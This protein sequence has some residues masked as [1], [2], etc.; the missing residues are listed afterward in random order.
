MEESMKALISRKVGMTS[1]IADDGV[2]QAVTLLSA[3]PC[4][5]TQ[6]KTDEVDGYTAVQI[7][8]GEAKLGKAQPRHNK[9][10][11]IS[12][13]IVREFRINEITEEIKVGESISADVFSVGDTVHVTGTS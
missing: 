6:L 5:I 12:P 1:I 13:K 7:G 11:K 9:P 8:T 2:V 4:V 10:S 3:A